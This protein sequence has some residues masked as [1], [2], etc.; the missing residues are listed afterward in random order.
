MGYF[1]A[2][3]TMVIVDVFGEIITVCKNNNCQVYISGITP[4]L[5]SVL[6]FGG[7]K[8]SLC[9]GLRFV[10]DLEAALGKAEDGLLKFVYKVEDQERARMKI[11]RMSVDDDGFAYALQQIDSQVSQINSLS[12]WISVNVTFHET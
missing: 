7:V 4:H 9:P 2:H 12:A 3:F 1:R 11:R 6:S 8:P 5:K 10:P